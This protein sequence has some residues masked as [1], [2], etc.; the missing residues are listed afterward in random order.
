MY[1][2]D[3]YPFHTLRGSEASERYYAH[4]RC[5]A[6]VRTPAHPEALACAA[7]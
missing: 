5:A 7:R 6:P 3:P 1:K 4:A 2:R